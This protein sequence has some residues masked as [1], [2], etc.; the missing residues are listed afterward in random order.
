[1]VSLVLALATWS[2][3]SFA[4]SSLEPQVRVHAGGSWVS[5]PSPFGI[6]AGIDARLTRILAID[7]AGFVTPAPIDDSEYVDREID[8][9][10]YWLRHAVY[11]APGIRIPHA[12]P[13]TW[14]W[15]VFV[16]GGAG[17]VWFADTHPEAT[18]LDG[19]D[20]R[21]S[22]SAAGNAGLDVLARFGKAGIRVAGKAWFYEAQHPQLS[23]TEFMVQPQVT[24]EG[25]WQF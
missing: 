8:T 23:V 12:Q 16:R 18:G 2:E 6:N 13:R 15:D 22:P 3:D 4:G 24:V 5:G 25:L 21:T 14:A 17:V 9:E 1:M 7:L 19:A 10:Y 11:F 20:R